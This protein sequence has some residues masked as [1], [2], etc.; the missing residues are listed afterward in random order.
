MRFRA[1]LFFLCFLLS[2]GSSQVQA[3]PL[4]Q[5]NAPPL[6]ERWFGILLN[7]EKT[8]FARIS[9]ED[10]PEGYRL[11]YDEGVKMTVLGF[12]R[13]ASSRQTY[14]VNR[15]LTLKRFTVELRIDASVVTLSG[16][17]VPGGIR[18][19]VESAGTRTDKELKAKGA[20]YPPVVLNMV[21]LM[22]GAAAGKKYRMQFF[23]P[24]SVKV[25]N[26]IY[27][28]V[29]EE[30]LAGGAKAIH[31]QND[32]YTVVSNDIW[33]DTAGNTLRE[34]VRDGLVESR[35][36]SAEEAGRFITEA[37]LSR[38][39]LILDFSRVKVDREIERSTDLKRLVLDIAGIPTEMPLP[40]QEWQ[41]AERLVDGTVRFTLVQGSA[42][43]K[44][45][46]LPPADAAHYLESNE[47]IPADHPAIIAKRNEI[48][49]AEKDHAA[50]VDKLVK[51]VAD[52]VEDRVTDSHSALETLQSRTGNCQ[53]HARLYAA[54][55]RSA[56]IPTR[57][58]SGLVYAKGTGFLYHSWAESYVNGWQ[59]VDPTFGQVPAEATHI[60]LVEG[61]TPDDM[62]PL[63]GVMG[64][65]KAKVVEVGYE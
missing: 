41:Q 27:S 14:I 8:G 39:D 3:R 45:A 37:A 18:V 59:P 6:G 55:A 12:T 40:R 11:Q 42:A 17:A 24:E 65:L 29:G 13:D 26:V 64:R 58:V 49:A 50:I 21:P 5:I 43:R 36:E 19:A 51:W 44:E 35:A 4:S 62:M 1:A 20:V 31:M 25:K 47:R 61:E 54:L 63:A 2:L 28:V 33:V 9:V 10:A 48:L 15:D 7:D 52:Y 22:K 38:K 16:E 53:S 34:S 23:D 46:R 56:G 60:K 57:F 32:I 30:T